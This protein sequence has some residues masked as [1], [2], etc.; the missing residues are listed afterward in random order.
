MTPDIVL[1]EHAPRGTA[2]P[3]Y[4]PWWAK[5]EYAAKNG[6]K[7]RMADGTSIVGGRIVV[8]GTG[9]FTRA[10]A[11]RQVLT[12][13]PE[14]QRARETPRRAPKTPDAAQLLLAEHRTRDLRLELCKRY[15]LDPSMLDGPNPGVVSMRLLNAL[16][17]AG[18]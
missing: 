9:D 7:Y 13:Q 3:L 8:R 11:A 16:R 4:I 5:G 14:V 1:T 18:L 6:T 10:P 12:P 17:R 15:S 2:D